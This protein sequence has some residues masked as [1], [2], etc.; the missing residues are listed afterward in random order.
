MAM[1]YSLTASKKNFDHI[2]NIQIENDKRWN[3]R[4]LGWF[5]TAQFFLKSRNAGKSDLVCL[6]WTNP[7]PSKL[8]SVILSFFW[9][10]HPIM[11]WQVVE[12]SQLFA[13]CSATGYCNLQG[14]TSFS[15]CPSIRGR[16]TTVLWCNASFISCLH[17][18]WKQ[19]VDHG[20]VCW[21]QAALGKWTRAA[22]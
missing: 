1:S 7:P 20:I 2:M 18:W 3:F 16:E 14:Y 6:V 9:M 12:Y 15:F 8:S 10:C 21:T 5:L 19:T 22:Y 11:A 4:N 13:V 17:G